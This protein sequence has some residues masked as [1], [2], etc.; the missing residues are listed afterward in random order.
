MT[1]EEFA[2]A[3]EEQVRLRAVSFRREALQDFVA[4]VWPL[5]QADPDPV[6]WAARFVDSGQADALA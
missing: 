4:A 5:A 3:L 6:Y 2:T 1:R